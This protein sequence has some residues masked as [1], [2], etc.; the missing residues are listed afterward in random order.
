MTELNYRYNNE[1]D[2]ERESLFKYVI[3]LDELEKT[4]NEVGPK[5][6]DNFGKLKQFKGGS[7]KKWSRSTIFIIIVIVLVIIAVAIFSS[8]K[9]G[10]ASGYSNQYSDLYGPVSVNNGFDPYPRMDFLSPEIGPDVRMVFR[11]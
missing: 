2:L 10:N 6:P 7:S 4:I 9:G 3:E 5:D 1:I 11:R 8:C